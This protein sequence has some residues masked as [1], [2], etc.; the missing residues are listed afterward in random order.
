MT[1]DDDKTEQ[2]RLR[3]IW[4]A[5]GAQ[6]GVDACVLGMIQT[7]KEHSPMHGTQADG[8]P[9]LGWRDCDVVMASGCAMQRFYTRETL[10]QEL[11]VLL[12][13]S[14]MVDTIC[15]AVERAKAAYP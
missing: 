8:G 10:L 2:L 11:N 14:D 12:L 3:A 4:T 13:T 1:T 9:V 5:H 15:A 7:A 6:A